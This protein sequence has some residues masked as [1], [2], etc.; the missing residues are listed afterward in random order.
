MLLKKSGR[1]AITG[2]TGC[3]GRALIK[4]L[5][6]EGYMNLT[7]LARN[8]GSLIALKERYPN[9]SIITGDISDPWAVTKAMQG[10]DGV[11]HG[12]AFK[13]VGMAEQQPWQCIQSNVIGSMNIVEES[14]QTHPD[15]VIGI[16]TD[17]VAQVSG[18]YGATKLCMEALLREAESI[19]GATA[20]RTVRY[21][22]IIKSTGSFLTKWEDRMRKGEEITLTDPDMTRFFWS[23]DEAVEAIF[24]CLKN[25]PDSKPWISKMK[26]IRLGDALKACQKVWGDTSPVKVIGRKVFSNEVEQ[27]TIDE[28]ASFL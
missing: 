2:G 24:D 10:I 17:K 27:F 25:A 23:V 19:N 4:R 16:S 9:I 22:N 3:L 7:V 18:I 8:E 28:F 13:H 1:Y 6:L 5:T 15:F 14:L 21:G 26:G 20:Y 11:F 12:A